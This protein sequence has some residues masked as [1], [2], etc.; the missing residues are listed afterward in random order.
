[1]VA[2]GYAS[3]V[4][5]GEREEDKETLGRDT[6]QKGPFFALFGRELGIQLLRS[7]YNQES[8]KRWFG[9]AAQ[10]KA[11]RLLVDQDNDDYCYLRL[12]RKVHAQVAYLVLNKNVL[13]I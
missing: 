13:I 5:C 7:R 4:G 10:R 1:M 12:Q 2:A 3:I 6:L 8:L 11:G 9:S